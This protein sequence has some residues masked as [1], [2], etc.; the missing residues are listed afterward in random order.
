MYY[1][2]N[3]VL[4]CDKLKGD[5]SMS[6]RNRSEGW[7][8]AKRSGH[9]NEELVKLRLETD[10]E[11]K[12]NFL[13]QLGIIDKDIK[14]IQVGGLHERDVE[15]VLEK[16]KTKSKTDLCILFEDGT[17]LN[18]S[19][20]K[21][22]GGQVY[23][24][25]YGNFVMGYEKQF[26][27]QIPDKVKRAIELF[28][29]V[30]NDVPNIA[31]TIGT[32]KNYELKKHRIVGDTLGVYSEELYNTLLNW[33]K[34]NMYNIVKFCF[35]MGLAAKEQDWAEV[36]WYVNELGDG[37][38]NYACNIDLLAKKAQEAASTEVCYGSRGH[39]TTIR[40]PFGFVQWHS[41]TK[42]IPGCLQFHHNLYKIERLTQDERI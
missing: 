14:N 41:P 21:S 1:D 10:V 30:A 37:N 2:G 16:Y 32:N 11:F 28:W 9:D 31:Q 25:T 26:Q 7:I 4:A 6:K 29:G 35:S 17:C 39:G 13:E 19:I 22:T 36:I 15:S 34:D 23:L 8:Y 3:A 20:K 42:S 27:I 5:N 12:M 24:I 40:L 18:V 38:F 33:M